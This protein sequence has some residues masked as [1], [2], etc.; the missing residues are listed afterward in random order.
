MRNVLLLVAAALF[1]R[2]AEGFTLPG[3]PHESRTTQSGTTSWALSTARRQAS[4][5]SAVEATVAVEKDASRSVRR[6]TD[7]AESSAIVATTQFLRAHGTTMINFGT[8]AAYAWWSG[9]VASSARA[10]RLRRNVLSGAVIFTV[11]DVGAQYL[12]AWKKN[13]QGNNEKVPFRL[14]QRR[15]TISTALGAVWAGVANPAV[16]NAVERLLPGSAG[17]IGRV[18]LK[19]ALSCSVLSTAG[20]W[21]TMFIRRAAIQVCDHV[22]AHDG[23]RLVSRLRATAGE[24]NR[25]FYE[26]LTDDLKV[27]PLYDV[28]CYSVVPPVARPVTTAIMSSLWSM[29]MSIASAGHNDDETTLLVESSARL[30]PE[31]EV[32]VGVLPVS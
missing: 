13:R 9:H 12:T 27:W 7:G 2:G 28:L 11:G 1:D 25:D 29:Y 32:A 23:P 17:S 6:S 26:V 31:S 19:M 5:E 30:V 20:N 16:Y 14:D 21:I 24:C 4:L 3:L 18:L 22:V 8:L 15:L 10:L